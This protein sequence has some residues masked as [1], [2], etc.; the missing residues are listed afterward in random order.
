MLLF[1]SL[2]L[3]QF[4][5]YHYS[6]VVTRAE[7]KTLNCQPEP[8]IIGEQWMNVVNFKCKIINQL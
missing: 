5:C 2:R 7:H 4:H 6:N 3:L 8:Y 1:F